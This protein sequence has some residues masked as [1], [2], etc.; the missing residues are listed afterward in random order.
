MQNSDP[1]VNYRQQ[2]EQLQA[3]EKKYLQRKKIFGGSRFFLFVAAFIAL[4]Q[5][6]PVGTA[7]AFM[8]F[9]ILFGLF[10]FMAA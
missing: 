1:E 4:W 10:L 5:L 3:I 9:I 6:W 8:G 2:I 7:I